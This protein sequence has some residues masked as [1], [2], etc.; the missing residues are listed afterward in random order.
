M[1]PKILQVPA[2][3]GIGRFGNWILHYLAGKM[4]AEQ[5]NATLQCSEWIGETLFKLSDERISNHAPQLTVL[6]IGKDWEG[7]KSLPP[8]FNLPHRVL[9]PFITRPNVQRTF[10]WRSPFDAVPSLD[11]IAKVAVHVRRGD[12]ISVNVWPFIPIAVLK[13]CVTTLGFNAKDILLVN[14]DVPNLSKEHEPVW[15]L[16]FRLLV[17]AEN[18]VVYPVSTFSQVAALLGNGNIYMPY[19]YEPYSMNIKY[20][21]VDPSEPVLFPTK[22]NNLA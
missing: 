15:L 17:W 10:Q 3:G 22:N 18:V 2:V 5:F 16:D 8:F 13:E 1:L 19:D 14:E 6:E 20:R 9:D 11:D 12:K 7:T 21:L 4:L